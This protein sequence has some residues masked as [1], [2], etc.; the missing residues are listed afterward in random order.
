M[1]SKI[2]IMRPKNAVSLTKH[3]KGK[4]KEMENSIKQPSAVS[5]PYTVV[6]KINKTLRNK[7]NQ[8]G[9]ENYKTLLRE[10]KDLIKYKDT[11]CSWIGRIKMTLLPKVVHRFNGISIKIPKIEKHILKF[12]WNFKRPK[13]PKRSS[14]SWTTLIFNLQNLLQKYSNQNSVWYWNKDYMNQRKIYYV[15]YI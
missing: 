2:Q 7:F 5:T 8:T 4:K 1:I 12:I 14:Q 6:L 11:P 9:T 15:P 3:F 10:I 13:Y